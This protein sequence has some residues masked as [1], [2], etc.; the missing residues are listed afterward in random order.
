MPD[1]TPQSNQLSLGEQGFREMQ[2]KDQQIHKLREQLS[3][4]EE[5]LVS[6][7][8]EIV[9]LKQEL[10]SAQTEISQLATHN[11]QAMRMLEDH[12]LFLL[13][14]T[15]SVEEILDSIEQDTVN[16]DLNLEQKLVVSVRRYPDYI[17]KAICVLRDTGGDLKS[18]EFHDRLA[19]ELD[20]SIINE[21]DLDNLFGWTSLDGVF[22]LYIGC[23]GA[24]MND[25]DDRFITFDLKKIGFQ[26]PKVMF[27][28][29]DGEKGEESDD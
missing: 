26:F 2:K 25:P 18:H 9:A 14:S 4:S 13:P 22:D 11:T 27:S 28:L 5:Q 29:N 20:M 10:S 7:D 17:R 16:L 6:K 1:S 3:K 23:L 19:E 8:Q 24:I 12:E 21:L 15:P